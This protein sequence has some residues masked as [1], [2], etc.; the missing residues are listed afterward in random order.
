MRQGHAQHL[1]AHR[2]GGTEQQQTDGRGEGGGN[3]GGHGGG[4]VRSSNQQV[5]HCQRL[6]LCGY[7]PSE[8]GGKSQATLPRALVMTHC[9]AC[10]Q[11][12][13]EL[14]MQ[15]DDRCC[16]TGTCIIDDNGRCWCGQQ[17][18]GEKMCHPVGTAQAP[19]PVPPVE[20]L[21]DGNEAAP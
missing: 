1:A 2:A 11:P 6:S 17:W 19:A 12:S 7:T 13:T 21:T 18:D 9:T 10:T 5:C 8:I 14:T 20:A 3:V 16:G 15:N 4:V